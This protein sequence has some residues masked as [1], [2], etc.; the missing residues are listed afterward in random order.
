MATACA[1]VCQL[2]HSLN[3]GGAEVLAARLARKLRDTHRFVFACLDG[4]GSLAEQL[5]DEGF[6][7]WELR[8][9]PG[10]DWRCS[11]RLAE[12]L[13]SERVDLVHAHQYTPFFYGA[14]ARVLGPRPPILFTEHG[15]WFPD[16]PR[17]K[18]MLANRL[19]L[20]RRDR[21]VGVGKSVRQ[22]LIRNE[23][24]PADRVGVIHNG[25]DLAVYAERPDRRADARRA[26]GVS[27]DEFVIIQVARLDAL[28]D[29]PT[30]V[31]AFERVA[32]S[33]P[34]AVLVLVGEGP[35]EGAIREEV[36]RRGLGARVR[37]LGLRTDVDDLLSGSEL[38]L[39][40]SVSE[41]I[42]VTLIEAMGAA[43]PVVATRVGGVGEVVDDGV[44]GLLAPSGDDD[45][46]SEHILG[47][48]EDPGRRARMG[49]AGRERA[50]SHFS[51]RR[52]HDGYL[53]LYEEM[54][55]G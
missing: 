55:R 40:S 47:L 18:R 1:T 19:L 16:F 36:R 52:M 30:A 35:E 8:R 13:R 23:G 34:D 48:A 31:R 21:V 6:P 29:H 45:R 46:L 5:R 12:L 33:R 32:R 26:L 4:Q 22:A 42:P 28:K 2:L 25:V 20:E 50:L 14:T 53:R 7:V 17:R 3:V 49:R 37:F 9:K 51:E 15:R 24:L 43:L 44:T 38:F 54:L 10:F 41:G 39:L 11:R 27:E